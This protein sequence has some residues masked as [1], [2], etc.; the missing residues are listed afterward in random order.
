M[1]KKSLSHDLR[2]SIGFAF[3][4]AFIACVLVWLVWFAFGYWQPTGALA[5]VRL[6]LGVLTLAL[7]PFIGL[8]VGFAF[9]NHRRTLEGAV[10][11]GAAYGFFFGL[12]SISLYGILGGESIS[13]SMFG[14]L[15]AAIIVGALSGMLGGWLRC[16]KDNCN[17]VHTRKKRR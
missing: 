6:F 2:G 5:Q 4:F 11:A 12:I 17:K 7:I 9:F 3:P 16:A 13:L 15:L 14:G 10:L 1:G 8:A